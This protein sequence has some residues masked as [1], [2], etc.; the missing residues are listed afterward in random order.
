ME[1]DGEPME[2]RGFGG[3]MATEESLHTV[4]TDTVVEHE[5]GAPSSVRR[6]YSTLEGTVSSSFG[7]SEFETEFEAALDGLTLLVDA[8][9]DA[10]VEDG[11]T[12]D[13]DELLEGHEPG[14][15]L[16]A[17]L[18]EG[19]A[20][21]GDSWDIEGEAFLRAVGLDL[22]PKLFQA[23]EREERGGGEGRRGRRGGGRSRGGS[24]ARGLM[25]ID[26][27]V[28][29]TLGEAEAYEGIDCLVIALEVDGEGDLPEGPSGGWREREVAPW[30]A[31]SNSAGSR[32]VE[33]TMEVELSGHLY[34]SLEEARPVGLALEGTMLSER[35][36][37]RE[38]G[39]SLMVISI[40]QEG[41]F[42]HEVSI[43][44]SESEE[45]EE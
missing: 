6:Y 12:P 35:I 36:S 29:A 27:T 40:T 13:D 4:H 37:E 18:P 26:W 10:E 39:E 20:E 42:S 45:S 23:P 7:E 2:G 14:L 31:A 19:G 16:D 32:V 8:E 3:G 41:T 25:E 33:S 44:E 22:R 38:M 9:G 43:T 28:E 34:F 15:A 5:D 24:A 21:V 17:L 11:D 30:F 1:R